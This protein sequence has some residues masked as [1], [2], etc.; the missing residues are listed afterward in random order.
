MFLVFTLYYMFYIEIQVYW[1]QLFHSSKLGVNVEGRD[2]K[3]TIY[4]LNYTYLKTAWLFVYSLVFVIALNLFNKFKLKNQALTKVIVVL[5]IS[6]AAI[7]L[8]GGLFNLS[9]MRAIFISNPYDEYYAI[10]SMNIIMRYISLAAFGVLAYLTTI[11]SKVFSSIS[12]YTV[13]KD[14][15]IHTILFW[16]LCS[17]LIHWL[18]MY[19]G[20][21]SYKLGL[22]ILWGLYSLMLIILGIWKVKKHIRLAGFSL[23]SLTLLKLFFYDITSLDTISK[24]IIFVIIGLLMLFASYLY[25]RYQGKIDG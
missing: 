23:F 1:E 12:N 8:I 15:A 9:L 21:A 7:F 22:S 16:L 13:Y 11:E 6:A 10:G 25:N 24:T 14:I 2:Y 19:S 4:N 18:D 20:E 3:E 5:G 17:E